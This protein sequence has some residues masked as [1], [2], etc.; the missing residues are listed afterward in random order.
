MDMLACSE[1]AETE[2]MSLYCCSIVQNRQA[3][4]LDSF[5]LGSHVNT[6]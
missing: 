3:G 4:R 1:S 6:T 2:N 5:V